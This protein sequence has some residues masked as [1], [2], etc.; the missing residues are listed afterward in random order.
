V[1]YLQN[2]KVPFADSLLQQI[3]AAQEEAQQ[4]Q[5]M[6]QQQMEQQEQTA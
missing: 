3:R 6:M 5:L 4:Q 2:A 1:Q